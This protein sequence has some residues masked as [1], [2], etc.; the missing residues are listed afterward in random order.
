MK[1][2]IGKFAGQSFLAATLWCSLP[3]NLRAGP[4]TAGDLEAAIQ[5]GD[6]TNYQTSAT[7]WLNEQAAGRTDAAT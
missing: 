3:A 7:A 1:N 2:M 5:S 6:F 4:P